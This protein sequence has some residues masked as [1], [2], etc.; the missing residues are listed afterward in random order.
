MIIRI[1]HT[2]NFLTMG[3]EPLDNPNL[4]FKAKGVLAYL[5]SRPRE[6][7]VRVQD[8]ENHSKDGRDSIRTALRQLR[9]E[10]YAYIK[11]LQ[12]KD[13][14]LAGREW[15][16]SEKKYNSVAAVKRVS[17]P[18]EKPS[19]VKSAAT[20]NIVLIKNKKQ[21][22][23]HRAKARGSEDSL[24]LNGDTPLFEG[25]KSLQKLS[26]K[27]HSTQ[28]TDFIVKKKWLQQAKDFI[29]DSLEGKT[30]HFLEVLEYHLENH[31][32]R[33]MPDC[34]TMKRF[35][36]KFHSIV[37]VM[38]KE[39]GEEIEDREPKIVSS[40]IVGIGKPEDLNYV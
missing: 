15:V 5:L 27:R 30:E 21:L 22:N 10:G 4:S 17:R 24:G 32:L 36:D 7:I 2:E 11:I 23:T 6:W 8:L 34:P 18:S 38:E 40:R 19:D 26:N 9:K 29:E 14:R 28:V 20:N 1:Q 16:I 33:F 3:K 37:K 13:G 35:C 12:G 39:T 25:C 31:R